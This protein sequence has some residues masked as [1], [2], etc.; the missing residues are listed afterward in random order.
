MCE[1]LLLVE[2]LGLL[3]REWLLNVLMLW[4]EL[5]MVLD[6]LGLL[7]WL[8]KNYLRCSISDINVC[9][10]ILVC[11]LLLILI[12]ALVL[13]LLLNLFLYLYLLLTSFSTARSVD[14]K[15]NTW[16]ENNIDYDCDN[17]TTVITLKLT[18]FSLIRRFKIN[19]HLKFI[20]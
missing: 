13:C 9:I 19:I 2:C 4:L 11:L 8:D 6:L 1:L 16:P 10:L 18:N 15:S 17:T 3:L 5:L 12:L 20:Y 14:T 7:V